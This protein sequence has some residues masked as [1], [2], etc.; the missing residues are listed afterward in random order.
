MAIDEQL[1]NRIRTILQSKGVQAVEKR[2]FSGIAFMVRGNMAV[3]TWSP[4]S[5]G[6]APILK[7][8]WGD[9]PSKPRSA[10]RRGM[11]TG[12]LMARVGPEQNEAALQRPLASQMAFK[13]P[14]VGYITIDP[15]GVEEDA[16]LSDW[17]DLCLKF[18][19]TLPEKQRS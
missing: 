6:T 2:M 8:P 19:Q 12:D 18:N 11:N 5:K 7:R 13:Q 15:A 3:G 1:A 16:D 14:M 17:I 4:T 10:G 9:I